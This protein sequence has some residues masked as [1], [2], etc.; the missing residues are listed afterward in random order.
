MK[1]D[2]PRLWHHYATNFSNSKHKARTIKYIDTHCNDYHVTMIRGHIKGPDIKLAFNIVDINN[3]FYIQLTEQML[4][5]GK[6]V[7]GKYININ[8]WRI[9][10]DRLETTIKGNRLDIL[11]NKKY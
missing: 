8:R 4:Y 5:V 10:G 1:E 3:F 2:D 9:E 6:Y 7:K 11:V